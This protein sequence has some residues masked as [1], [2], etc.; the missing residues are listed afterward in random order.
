MQPEPTEI[1]TPFT[2]TPTQEQP[3]ITSQYGF[4]SPDLQPHGSLPE[5][6]RASTAYSPSS[7]A[8]HASVDHDG[9]I[10]EPLLGLNVD[11]AC[12][13]H[14]KPTA[15]RISEHENALAS[16]PQKKEFEGPY[17]R[18]VKSSSTLNGPRLE[19]FP[20]GNIS[21]VFFI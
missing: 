16:F 6:Q 18:V 8:R 12:E 10:P 2:T 11:V 3:A 5:Q 13:D 19:N 9:A 4:Q 15:H 14:T 1:L 20:N 21:P 17:F 7:G